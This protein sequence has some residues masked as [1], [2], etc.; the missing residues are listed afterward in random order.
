M[1]DSDDF[2]DID[3][4]SNDSGSSFSDDTETEQ[5][6]DFIQNFFIRTLRRHQYPPLSDGNII[7]FRPPPYQTQPLDLSEANKENIC[8]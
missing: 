3:Q 4:V 1:S 5:M 6:M 2:R 8:K 7:R